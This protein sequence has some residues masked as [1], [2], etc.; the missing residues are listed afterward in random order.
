MR[1]RRRRKRRKGMRKTRRR[2]S[3]IDWS[4]AQEGNERYEGVWVG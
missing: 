3:R 4:K 1:R 2:R